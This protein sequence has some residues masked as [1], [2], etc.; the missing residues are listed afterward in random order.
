MFLHES[1]PS[2]VLPLEFDAFPLNL[3]VFLVFFVFIISLLEN[4]IAGKLCHHVNLTKLK[5]NEEDTKIKVHA[6]YRYVTKN[7]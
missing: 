3:C 4:W 2:L 7:C 5:H 6:S 1:L